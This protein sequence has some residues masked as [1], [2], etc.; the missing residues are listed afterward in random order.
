MPIITDKN[1]QLRTSDGSQWKMIGKLS[2]VGAYTTGG[3]S[4]PISEF[5]LSRLELFSVSGQEQGYGFEYDYVN[6]KLK[7]FTGS[8]S[9]ATSPESA[10]T[11]TGTISSITPTGTIGNSSGGTP[12]GVVSVPTFTGDPLPTHSHSTISV[13]LANVPITE[14]RLDYVLASVVGAFQV[15]ETITG[16]TTG[17]TAVIAAINTGS[18]NPNLGYFVVT[19]FTGNFLSGETVTGGT[20]G[21]TATLIFDLIDAFDFSS[22]FQSLSSVVTSVTTNIDLPLT[23]GYLD[24]AIYPTGYRFNPVDRFIETPHASG[25]LTLSAMGLSGAITNVSAGTPSGTNSA[26]LFT[27]DLLAAHTHSFAGDPATPIFIGDLMSTHFH[28]V[29]GT[30]GEV[31][32]GTDLSFLTDVEFEAIGL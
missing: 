21:A 20:S 32:N 7:V 1:Q 16:G 11:P 24:V 30:G 14:N 12:S 6:Q 5:G 17:D 2:F 9:G 13:F 28:T 3:E 15:G 8:G 31:L 25:W 29:S 22:I 19:G 26:P 4:F 18:P 23:Q 27:G 10:G